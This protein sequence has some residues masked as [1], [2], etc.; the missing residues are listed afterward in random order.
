VNGEV[1]II[2]GRTVTVATNTGWRNVEVPDSATIMTEGAG[3]PA[4]LVAGTSVAVTSKPD[5][6]A[7]S[8]R[9]FPPGATAR[10]GQFPM[11]G[12]QA[13]NLM[14]NAKVEAFD[15]KTMALDYDGQK[16]SIVVPP[17]A[18]IVKPVPA[19]FSDIK[20]GERVQALG[21]VAGDTLTARS[22]T[23]VTGQRTGRGAAAASTGP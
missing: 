5:G 16:A 18:E 14:T 19:T 2:D 21:T 13:G 8:I 10:T 3:S 1:D 7:L 15:G 11:N 22:V 20:I 17:E 12:P 6:T 9:I 23:I 4:D